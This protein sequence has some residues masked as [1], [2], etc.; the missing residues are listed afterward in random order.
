M[1]SGTGTYFAAKLLNQMFNGTVYAFVTNLDLRLF[2]TGGL[3]AAGAGTE[4]TG[5]GYGALNVTCNVTN[6][7]VTATNS[8]SNAV[9]LS[10]V[11][12]GGPWTVAVTLGIY[13]HGNNNLVVFGD[14]AA[15]KTLSSGDV[16]QFT[17]TNLTITQ[18]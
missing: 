17:P 5:T 7:P 13:E 16:F 3:T 10:F 2:S 11:A 9:T 4:V 6:F 1:A 15:T 8:I 12:A 18:S 14:L